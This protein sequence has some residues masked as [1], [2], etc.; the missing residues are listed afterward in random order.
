MI[1]IG[2]RFT[3]RLRGALLLAAAPAL[4]GGCATLFTGTKD[5]LS[6][7]ANVPGVRLT[8][9]GQYRG[10]L[11]LTLEM[12]RNFMGGQQ[13]VAT[14]EKAGYQT[15]EFKLNREFNPVA[16]LDVTSIPTSG[17][18]DVVSGSLLRFSPR[19]YQVQMLPLSQRAGSREPR[20]SVEA[21][22]FALAS[23]RSIQKDLARGGGEHLATLAHLVA[24]GDDAAARLVGA[25]SLRGARALLDASSAPVFVGRLDGVLAA[26]PA[27]RAYRM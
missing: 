1:P 22:G 27:L 11:P 3:A 9:D 10:E 25:A 7:A 14:F 23:F 19:E 2:S 4:L 26:D 18:V 24:G 13:F 17:G 21:I 20:R 12:S 16:I 8:I 6:F 15:Q 5:K